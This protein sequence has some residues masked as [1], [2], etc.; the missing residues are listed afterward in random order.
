MKQAVT[1]APLFTSTYPHAPWG[2]EQLALHVF[3][4]A[5]Q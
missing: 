3:G 2:A 4:A 5:V 1:V